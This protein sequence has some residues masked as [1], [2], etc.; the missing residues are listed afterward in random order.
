MGALR[1][2]FARNRDPLTRLVLLVFRYGQWTRRAP[3]PLRLA[4]RIPYVLANLLVCRIAAGIDLPADVQCGPGL[5]LHHCGRGVCVNRAAVLGS[6]VTI[7]QEVAVGNTDDRGAPHIGDGVLIGVGACVLGPI[8][9][10]AGA[11]IAANATV[12]DDV[13]AG[14]VALGPRAEIRAPRVRA[15]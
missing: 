11:R 9:V 1:E 10:G 6:N 7:F 13:P 8:T 5:R 3:R 2:D 15:A 12:L 4:A 14:G